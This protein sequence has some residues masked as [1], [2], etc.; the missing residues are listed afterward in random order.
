MTN[1][2]CQSTCESNVHT[3]LK[4]AASARFASSTTPSAG[5]SFCS[6]TPMS[7]PPSSEQVVGEAAAQISATPGPAGVFA[8]GADHLAAGQDGVYPAGD[9]PTLPGGVIH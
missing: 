5:G 6:T 9:L 2:S 8:A 7:M 1:G 4:P 3:W